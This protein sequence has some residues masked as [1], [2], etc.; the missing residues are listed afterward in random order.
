MWKHFPGNLKNNDEKHCKLESNRRPTT[1]KKLDLPRVQGIV[2][3]RS[4]IKIQVIKA[5][6]P[7]MDGEDEEEQKKKCWELFN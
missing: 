7:T 2:E 1:G 4:D 6:A 3:D 5:I